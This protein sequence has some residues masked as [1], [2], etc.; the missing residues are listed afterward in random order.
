MIAS[1]CANNT[2]NLMALIYIYV[3]HITKIVHHKAQIILAE[4]VSIQ[5]TKD[6]SVLQRA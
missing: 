1:S 6:H 5:R 3:H 2:H 4:Q